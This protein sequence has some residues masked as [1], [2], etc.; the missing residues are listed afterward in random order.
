MSTTD[1][2]DA[3]A[4]IIGAGP[5]GIEMHIALK[6]AGMRAL[7]FEAGQVGEVI[8]RWAPFTEFFSTP[9]R[10]ALAGVPIPNLHQRRITG[11]E[12]VAY[13]RALV[14]QFDLPIH[15]HEPVTRI[16]PLDGGGF[17][18]TTRHLRLGE[19][20]YTAR[21]V[22]AA[23]GGMAKP[24][25]LGIPGEDLPH[26]EHAFIG[27]HKYFRQRVLVVGGRN[28]AGE[29][30]LRCWRA[31]SEVA[32]SYRR[33]ELTRIK[34]T[35]LEELSHLIDIGKV[36]FYP[37]TVPTAISPQ[38]VTLS[39]CADDGTLLNGEDVHHETDFVLMM[40]GFVADMTLLGDAGV[41]LNPA[42]Q[43]PH[44]DP[45][46]MQTN[47]PGLYVVGTAAGGT[48]NDGYSYFIETS[49]K[50]VVTITEGLTGQRPVVGRS[51]HHDYGF[52]PEEEEEDEQAAPEAKKE[53]IVSHR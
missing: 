34:H 42:N 26:V 36:G 35:I 14:E 11:E 1:H 29:A 5:V 45:T 6:R 31:G 15:F 21:H 53:T 28:S 23:T 18:I 39:P 49:H 33:G 12:Y 47:V 17:A 10:I 9:E 40:T 50:H 25:R 7:H 46:T 32:I 22:I 8:T 19:R 20:R 43:Q 16:E 27:P 13:L 48:Q 3:P 30:A 2:F 37:N 4:A 52:F 38:H 51:P 41:R 24:N 44:Y